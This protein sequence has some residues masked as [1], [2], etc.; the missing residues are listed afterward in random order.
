MTQIKS[1]IELTEEKNKAVVLHYGRMNPPTKGHEENINGVKELAAKHHADH[2]VVASHSQDKKKNP[3]SPEQ[4]QKHLNRAFPDTNI[5]VASKEHPTII[6]H[7]KR[8]AAKGYNHLIVAAGA[9]RAKEYHDLLHKYNGKEYNFKKITV[10]STGQR[11]EGVSGT[12]MRNHAKNNDYGSFKKNLPSNIQKNDKHSRELFHDT[13]SGMGLHESANRSM[14]KA[15]FLVGG[16][17]SG[18]DVIIREAIAEKNAVE[19]NA[20]KAY[21]FIIDKL[22]LSEETKDYQ[23]NAIRNR[24]ALV[25]NGASDDIEKIST[26]KEELEELGYT[27]MMVFVNTTN[28]ISEKRNQQHSRIISEQ[29]R[30]DKWNKSQENLDKFY[31]IFEAFLEFDN[32]IN[33][34]ESDALVR[35]NKQNELSDMS[36]EISFFFRAK[37]LTES[38]KDWLRSKDR[39][40]INEDIKSLF[41]TK[42]ILKNSAPVTQMIRKSGKQDDV[43]DGDVKDNS[44]Y[45]FKTYVESQPTLKINPTPKVPNFDTDKE[46]KKNKRTAV[47]NV[48]PGKVMNGTGV[49][50]TWDNRTSGTVYPMSGLGN[51]T[52]R[53]SFS[54]FRNKV[55]EA[56]D[57]PGASDM[58]MFGGMGNAVNKEPLETP[59]NKFSSSGETTKK[60]K[61]NKQSN[62][63]SSVEQKQTSGK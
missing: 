22:K 48:L 12:D 50:D 44:S 43:R 42:K 4:K 13:R 29:I 61:I 38:A 30:L 5:E 23:L 55:K 63:G 53:E 16:P 52:Y 14:F 11:K 40:D 9:D 6:H 15:L 24:N 17:G 33:L 1:F 39:L 10:T 47:N 56:I 59:L 19:I 49:G 18:K 46:T 27:T 32:S 21:D 35:E 54:K 60:K 2:L 57:D 25:I 45:I 8:L 31:D 28:E 36:N 41:E 58:G 7:A 51:V 37:V 20:N 26:I 62:I 34:Q 3:L